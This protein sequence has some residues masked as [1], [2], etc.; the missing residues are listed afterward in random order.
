MVNWV[1]ASRGTWAACA[2]LALSAV[3]PATAGAAAPAAVAS[4]DLVAQAEQYAAQAFE[5]YRQGRHTDAVALYELAYAS[6]PS[7]DALYNIARV[8]DVG[9]RDRERALAA[10]ERCL[11]E[12]GATPERVARAGERIGQLRRPEPRPLPAQSWPGEADSPPA[13]R[14][15]SPPLPAG[16][17]A[18]EQSWS[19]LRGAA[20]IAG[21]AGIVGLGAGVGFGVAASSDARR[22]NAACSGNL[23]RTQQ[24]V[25]A[26]R[27]AATR[28]T[29]ATVGVGVGTALLA[30]GAALWLVS[31]SGTAEAA[32]EGA[33]RAGVKLT[34]VAGRREVG[35]AME[36]RW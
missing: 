21:A 18:E 25:D 23:C 35:V 2:L 8:Y 27:S 13:P 19:W 32:L 20:V 17:A 28:A 12:P 7:A 34:P 24:G 31:G 16:D 10:Y 26:A 9:L 29:L 14:L 6:A 15:P 30:S 36:G 5:A 4:T 33:P 1:G 22:A 11:L 3:L